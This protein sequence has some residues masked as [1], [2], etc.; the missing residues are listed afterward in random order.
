MVGAGKAWGWPTSHSRNPTPLCSSVIASLFGQCRG[1]LGWPKW[2]SFPPITRRGQ[3]HRCIA[4]GKEPQTRGSM[5][6][7]QTRHCHDPIQMIKDPKCDEPMIDSWL[8]GAFWRQLFSKFRPLSQS[9]PPTPSVAH[10]MLSP[11]P[12]VPLSLFI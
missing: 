1:S 7:G 2:E 6:L 3:H 9:P 8:F 5:V 11:L 4:H 12:A 10:T